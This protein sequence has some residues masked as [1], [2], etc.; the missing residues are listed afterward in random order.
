MTMRGASRQGLVGWEIVTLAAAGGGAALALAHWVS[1][2]AVGKLESPLEGEQDYFAWMYG[3]HK[4]TIAYQV[5]GRGAPLVLIHGVS[6][7]ASS[8]EYRRVFGALSR[9][10]R[11]FAFDLLGFGL[12]DHPSLVYTPTLYESLIEDFLTQVVGG[13]DHPVSVVAST[14]SA[15]FTI[16]AAAERPSLFERLV[17]IQPTGIEAL[18]DATET[19][20]KRFALALLRTPVFGEIIYGVI[21]SRLGI[22]Y[23]LRQ[24]YANPKALT[25]ELVDEYYAQA[26]QPGARFP[27]A[28]LLAGALNTPV[29]ELYMLL[30]LPILLVWGKNARTQPLERST[31][32]RHSN[33]RAELCVLDCGALPQDELPEEFVR[34]VGAWVGAPLRSRR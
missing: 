32:F 2:R 6:P 5:K 25:G 28:S 29:Q 10:F 9:R 3:G 30:R 11:V 31:A 4:Y 17:L 16:R 20:A 14:L 19:P 33:P 1:R 21:A 7:G 15:A 34:E 24:V 22:R 26:H 12:S 27:L 8:I 18:S 13:V 23:Q